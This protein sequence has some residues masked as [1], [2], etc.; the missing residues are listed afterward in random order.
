MNK[1]PFA[2][3]LDI[4]H[5][6]CED[7]SMRAISRVKEVS[8]NPVIKLLVDAGTACAVFHER[9]VRNIQARS[10]QCDELWAFCYAKAKNVPYAKNPGEGAGDIWTGVSKSAFV[11]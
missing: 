8:C 5:M 3:R 1:L 11:C 4:V 6:L 7:S 2:T 9:T 10:I